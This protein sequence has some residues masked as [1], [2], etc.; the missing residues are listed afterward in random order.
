MEEPTRIG[1]TQ[2]AGAKLEELITELNP[3]QGKEGVR[4]IKFD[5]YRLAISLGI[6]RDIKPPPLPEKSIANF[7]V[8]ELDPE[9]NLLTVLSLVGGDS[10]DGNAYE[11]MERL[12]E[13]GVNMFYEAYQQTGELPFEE[14]F[15]D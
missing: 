10:F 7:R 15:D 9:G 8:S 11:Y 5:L 4:L 3:E 2:T 14:Y 12:A 13:L 6:K 1:L